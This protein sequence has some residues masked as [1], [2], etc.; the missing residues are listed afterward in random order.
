MINSYKYPS[1]YELEQVLGQITDRKFL[2]EFAQKRGIF[3][4]NKRQGDLARE[5]SHLFFDNNDLEEIRNAAYQLNSNHTFT[6]FVIRSNSKNFSLLTE[7]ERVIGS[8]EQGKSTLNQLVR[9]DTGDD[10]ELYRGSLEYTKTK[11]DRIEFLQNESGN[12]DFYIQEINEGVWQVEVD[13]NRSTD[14]QDL[15]RI[16]EQRISDNKATEIVEIDQALLRTEQTI[17]FFD[18]LAK[19][20]FEGQ[21]KFVGAKNINIKK[22]KANTTNLNEDESEEEIEETE[23]LGINQAILHGQ[24]LRGEPFVDDLV[25][26]GFGFTAM[27]YEYRH[28]KD[29]KIITIKAEFKGRPKVFEVNIVNYEHFVGKP[30]KREDVR[31]RD[32]E[33]RK[34][35][36]LFWNNAKGIFD[37][38]V[39]KK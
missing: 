14:S 39:N 15:K 3:I 10:T 4:T 36:S 21:W 32:S 33:S 11:A 29:P 23:L 16:F 7:Y 13:C 1:T 9:V 19:H 30:T 26:K 35:K 27:T 34:Y 20:P 28:K 37:S 12:F 24:N 2:N 18:E 22:L 17:I 31:L 8:K 38:I 25:K 5:L 6:G